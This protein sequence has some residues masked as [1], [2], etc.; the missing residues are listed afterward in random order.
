MLFYQKKNHLL[1][2]PEFH[3]PLLNQVHTEGTFHFAISYR[4]INIDEFLANGIL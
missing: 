4:E 3:L 2:K 1:T